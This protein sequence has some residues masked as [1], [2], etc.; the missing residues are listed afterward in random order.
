MKPYDILTVKN[1]LANSV[2]YLTEYTICLLVT[3]VLVFFLWIVINLAKD[4]K[5]VFFYIYVILLKELHI[6]YV[7][8]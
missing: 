6:S 1:L 4:T 2:F 8:S 7:V 5:F 3:D